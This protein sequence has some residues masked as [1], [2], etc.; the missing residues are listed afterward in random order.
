V[1]ARRRRRLPAAGVRRARGRRLPGTARF[2]LVAGA[3]HFLQVERPD[4]VN[5]LIAEFVEGGP[6]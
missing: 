2:A 3:G 4:V 5:A 1:P 6:N